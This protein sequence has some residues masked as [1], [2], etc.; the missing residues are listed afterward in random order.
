MKGDANLFPD[1]CHMTNGHA[2]D[3]TVYGEKHKVKMKK[4]DFPGIPIPVNKEI[5][6]KHTRLVVMDDINLVRAREE[7]QKVEA[8]KKRESIIL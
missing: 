2:C 4:S 5:V 3:L 1:W 7:D 8:E 6:K